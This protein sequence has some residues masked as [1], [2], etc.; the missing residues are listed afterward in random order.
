MSANTLSPIEPTG[1]THSGAFT[2]ILSLQPLDEVIINFIEAVPIGI[3][4]TLSPITAKLGMVV[5]VPPVAV[6]FTVYFVPP[7][8]QNGEPIFCIMVG[9][10]LTTTL[11]VVVSKQPAGL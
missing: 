8:R 1:K 11:T 5:T 4:A 9:F 6:N 7:T 10:G 3:L 2:V